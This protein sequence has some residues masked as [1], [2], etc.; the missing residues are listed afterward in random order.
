MCRSGATNKQHMKTKTKLRIKSLQYHKWLAW[1]AAAALLLFG[2]SG[3]LHPLMLW[4]GPMPAA[5]FPPAAIM[6]PAQVA[7]IPHVLA[8]HHITAPLLVKLVPSADTALVQMTES[9][10]QPRR[11]FDPETA[12]ELEGHD[13][14]HAIDLAR[15]YSGLYEADVAAVDFQTGFDNAYPW[16]NRLL[17]VYRVRFDTPDHLTLYV[18]TELGALAGITNDWKTRLQTLFGWLHTWNFLDGAEAVR[19]AAM[20]VLLLSL[21]AMTLAGAA[22]LLTLARRSGQ[23]RGR[24][25]HRRLA[26]GLWLPLLA[27]SASGSYHLL[28]YSLAENTRGL[29]L[30]MPLPVSGVPLESTGAWLE[31]YSTQPLNAVSLVM[32]EG[33]A[34]F[35][36]LGVAQ[37]KPMPT[38]NQRYDG[39][40]SEQSAFYVDAVTGRQSLL[41]DNAM[42]RFVAGQFKRDERLREVSEI[43]GFSPAYDFRNKRLPVWRADFD[44]GDTLFIDPASGGLIDRVSRAE[45]V[46]NYVFSHAHKWNFLGDALGRMARDALVLVV[47][48]LSFALLV[49]GLRLKRAKPL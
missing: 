38:A 29:R 35:Y 17:P 44:G 45:K 23:S 33:G 18:H 16:V 1:M 48:A 21:F 28:Q 2:L 26:Y 8:R 19:V 39:V 30:G 49:L 37:D 13:M 9:H 40:A 31:R 34:L 20:G 32:G 41:T 47:L 14:R 6:Q 5:F 43:K 7:A 22:L 10:D 27:F 11:Y 36:R 24:R 12:L 4:T 3:A 15:Y 42:A 46:E 25:W